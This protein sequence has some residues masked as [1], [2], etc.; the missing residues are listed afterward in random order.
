MNH[1]LITGGAGFIGS[2]L[3]L[4]LISEGCR[5]TVLDSLS[6]QVHGSDPASASPLFR[7]IRDRVRFVRGSVTRRK[8]WLEALAGV[9][10]IVHLAAET[11]TGQSGYEIERYTDVNVRGT[12]LMLDLL[13]NTRHRVS[14]VVVASS[15]AVYG[16]GR[17]LSA[18][19]GIV[20]PPRRREED[21]LRGDFECKCEG[22]SGPLTPV[23]TGEDSPMHPISVYGI[24]KQAQE[25]LV[26]TVCPTLG[27]APVAIRYQNVYGPGQSLNNPYTGI[28]SIFSTR[29]RGG[30]E[31]HIFEDGR[32]SRD[33]VY[34]DDAVEATFFALRSDSADG[35]SINV[36]T[37]TATDVL[38]VAHTLIEQ[39]AARVPVVIT[40]HFRRGDIRHNF[41]DTDRAHRLLGFVPRRSFAEGIARFADWVRE[42]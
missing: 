39:F 40:G 29:I 9:E 1:V 23:G 19:S 4:R 34:I 8:D 33:F 20:Y 16:E 37:G 17:Y 32:E 21:M 36:G 26:M 15:R 12:A 10:V 35:R 13:A 14:K 6:P 18:G 30:E 28:L 31:I 42:Q 38:T 22:V 2:R 25:Q 11:G 41:A 3:A 5:V 27:I 24:T 7:S